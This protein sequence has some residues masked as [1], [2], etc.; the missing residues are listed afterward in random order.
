MCSRHL[1]DIYYYET[2]IHGR[3]GIGV[4]EAFEQAK[5]KPPL[6]VSRALSLINGVFRMLFGLFL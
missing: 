3:E 5:S 2:E 4:G 1:L 6:L